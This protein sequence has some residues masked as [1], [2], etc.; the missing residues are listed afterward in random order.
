MIAES[1][2]LVFNWHTVQESSLYPVLP[3]QQFQPPEL[4]NLI[5]GGEMNKD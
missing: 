4:N 1:G 5:E 2:K 3:D